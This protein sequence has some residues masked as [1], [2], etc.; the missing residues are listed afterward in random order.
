MVTIDTVKAID[1]GLQYLAR[2]QRPDGCWFNSGGYGG[3]NY[4]AVM[5]SLAGIAFLASGST[6]ESGPYS[7]QVKRAMLYVL[8]L[9]ESSSDGL[10]CGPT[11][12]ARSMY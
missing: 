9:A 12:E 10:I 3:Y 7:R 2:T 8:R 6:P 1:K 5:T 4:P 11:G